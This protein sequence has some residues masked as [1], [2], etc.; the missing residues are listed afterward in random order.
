LEKSSLEKEVWFKCAEGS[1]FI[2]QR[3]GVY[4]VTN[5]FDEL[6]L[7]LACVDPASILDF[8]GISSSFDFFSH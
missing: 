8:F 2:K 3:T 5:S 1:L 4:E 6:H 7:F